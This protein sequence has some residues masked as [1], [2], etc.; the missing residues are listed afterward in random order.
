MHF[1]T[2]ADLSDAIRRK[3]ISPVEVTQH[4]L[5]RIETT[6]AAYGAY[7]TVTAERALE[8]AA[9][10]EAAIMRGG[11]RGPLHGVPF[12]LKD[13]IYTDFAP[14]TGGTLINADFRA[15]FNAT[16]VERLEAQG[17]VTLGKV[18]TTEQAF[19][20]HHPSVQPPR[21]PWNPEYFS[22]V[23]SSGSGVAAAAGLAYG[24][25]GSDTGGSIRFPSAANGVTGLKPTWGRVSRY[26]VFPLAWSLDHIGPIARSAVDAAIILQ[27]IAGWDPR[28]PTALHAPVPDYLGGCSGS[29]SG[30]RIGLPMEY[31]TSGVAAEVVEALQGAVAALQLQGA[32]IKEIEFPPYQEALAAWGPLCSVETAM[33]HEATYPSRAK[34][35]GPVLAGFIE[36]GRQTSAR[37]LA[38]AYLSKFDFSNR[39]AG[40]F[41]EVDLLIIPTLTTCVPT[42]QAWEEAVVAG[43]LADAI[44]F[45]GPFDVSGSP[46]LTLCNGF[47]AKGLPLSFQLAGPHLSEG[48]LFKAG[49]AYQRVTDWHLRHP[50]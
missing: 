12:A 9:A 16:V 13:I 47:D 46:T 23:S 20:I 25:L 41:K 34:D 10:A 38:A 17:A 18:K 2:I 22:G 49:A 50:G 37:D 32:V 11:W 7:V 35:Y 45:T 27:A 31:A 5:R 6:H 39:L 30:L 15:E 19:A 21:N 26:G 33:A 4:M 14:T 40:V 28:D 24:T 29:I 48:L 1:Q 42:A 44:R 43:A 36:A 8:Q 3:S